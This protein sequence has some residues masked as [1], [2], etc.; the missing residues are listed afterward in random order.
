[1]I[2]ALVDIERYDNNKVAF[3]LTAWL[4]FLVPSLIAAVLITTPYP[5]SLRRFR[6]RWSDKEPRKLPTWDLCT[7]L[8]GGRS[9]LITS[10]E[11]CQC[12]VLL[13]DCRF[14]PIF[15]RYSAVQRCNLDFQNPISSVSGFLYKLLFAEFNAVIYL[16]LLWPSSS[17]TAEQLHTLLGRL[18]LIL[19]TSRYA[20]SAIP[21]QTMSTTALISCKPRQ[22][23]VTRHKSS[24]LNIFRMNEAHS[25]TYNPL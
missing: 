18:S 17:G 13:H 1:M 6:H 24:T 5:T 23:G 4:I 8:T 12:Y 25:R 10:G 22:S 7:L 15:C 9:Q 19:V 16:Y 21:P 14:L 11:L 3:F 20:D 2:Y